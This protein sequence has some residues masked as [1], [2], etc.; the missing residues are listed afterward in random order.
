MDDDALGGFLGYTPPLESDGDYRDAALR[1]AP[2]A[3]KVH[4]FD[5]VK[6]DTAPHDVVRH[7]AVKRDPKF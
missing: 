2:D 1:I 6:V 3:V 7:R 5:W 4:H